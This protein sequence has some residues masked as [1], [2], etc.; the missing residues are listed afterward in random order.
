MT[1]SWKLVFGVLILMV[2]VS[3]CRSPDGDLYAIQ[4]RW[5]MTEVR[6]CE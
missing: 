5:D 4:G 2:I 3:G 6:R 1:T